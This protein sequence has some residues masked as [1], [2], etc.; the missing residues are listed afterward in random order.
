MIVS[1]LKSNGIPLSKVVEFMDA[2]RKI[3]HKPLLL[4]P[5]IVIKAL[6]WRF[7]EI[8]LF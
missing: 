8:T 6:E 4:S 7:E 5:E 2:I 3:P 1:M